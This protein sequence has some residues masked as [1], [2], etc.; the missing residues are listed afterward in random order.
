MWLAF[1]S[2]SLA[3]LNTLAYG[4]AA[5]PNVVIILACGG[6]FE[7]IYCIFASRTPL[8][9]RLTKFNVRSLHS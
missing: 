7:L 1:L 4:K 8:T 5:R 3:N 6:P 2:C 9:A